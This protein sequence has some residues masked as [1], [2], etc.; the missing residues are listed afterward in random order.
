MIYSDIRSLFENGIQPGKKIDQEIID[1]YISWETGRLAIITGIPASGKSEFVD[2]IVCRLNINHGW[3]AAYFTPENYPL[4]FHYT[5]L[6]EKIIG[7]K[8]SADKVSEVEWDMAYEYI[9][10][11]FFYIL[12]EADFTI[13]SILDSTRILVKTRGIKI[14]VID[15]YNKLEHKYSDSETQYISRFLDELITFAKLN[16][17]LVFL[18]AHP[19]KMSRVNGKI[20]VPSLYDISGSANFYNKT[21]YGITVHRNTDDQ[22]VMIN[23]IKVYFQ[24][25]KYKHLGEQGIID[26]NYDYITGRFNQGGR[27]LSNWL[28]KE[29]P[30]VKQEVIDYYETD[31]QEAPF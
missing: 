31:K 10:D 23:E 30:I 16:D 28:I 11:N 25:I 4:K 5:K 6:F 17:V 2:Y 20:E 12:N 26:L 1:K 24:K 21:D 27:D 29:A 19:K 14:I 7:K 9:K 13:K 22:N 3:K 18:V 15:P 8:F